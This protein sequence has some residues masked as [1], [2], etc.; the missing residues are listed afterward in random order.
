MKI[1]KSKINDI[2][3]I[4]NL[5]KET[6]IYFAPF[7]NK[8]R[9][10]EKIEKEPELLL[11]AEDN[12]KIVGAVI[13]NYGWRISIDHMAID[14]NYQNQGI[15]RLLMKEIKRGL[16]EKGATVAIIDSNLPKELFDRK[17][18]EFRGTFNNYLTKL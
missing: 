9:L 11:I 17:G 14:K 16:K 3:Q 4:I 18:Y 7:D 12:N 5:W 1:R 10:M 15:A 13:G 6:G 8:E 2:E